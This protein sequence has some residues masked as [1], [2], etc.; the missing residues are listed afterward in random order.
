MANY[1]DDEIQQLAEE[2]HF[3]IEQ[4]RKYARET[5]EAYEAQKQRRLYEIIIA[6]VM[7]VYGYIVDDVVRRIQELLQGRI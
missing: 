7:S 4:D 3:Q 6:V 1:T 5:L 2:V